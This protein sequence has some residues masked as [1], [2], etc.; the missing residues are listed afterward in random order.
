[1][2]KLT[3]NLII[4]ILLFGLCGCQRQCQRMNK[5]YQ[6]TKRTYVVRMFS[7][8]DCVFYDSVRTIMNSEDGSDGCYYYKGDTLIEIS[9][10]YTIKSVK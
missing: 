10:D 9:G 5:H 8:G 2:N 3:K 6:T 4:C 1:M 7:G